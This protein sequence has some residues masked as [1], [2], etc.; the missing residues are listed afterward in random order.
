ML[1]Y[2]DFQGFSDVAVNWADYHS[3]H[4]LT[5]SSGLFCVGSVCI[6]DAVCE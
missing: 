2:V 6:M 5:L 1:F 4:V 3:G